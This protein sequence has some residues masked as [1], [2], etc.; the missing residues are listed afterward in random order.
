M[1]QFE[2]QVD[3]RSRSAMTDFLAHHF[4]YWTAN[5]WNRSTSYAH[6]MKID[7][8]GLLRDEVDILYDIIDVPEA[9]KKINVL[10]DDFNRK[11]DYEWQAGFN[12]RSGGYLVLYQGYKK[13]S[14][15]KS[16]CTNCG[17]R[18]YQSVKDTG[19]D[20]CGVCRDHSRVDYE[21]P[22][23]IYGTYPYIG[24]DNGYTAPEDYEDFSLKE[25]QERV[26]IVQDFDQLA[27]NIAETAK[28]L[29]DNYHVEEETI[30]VPK[31][32][33]KLAG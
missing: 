4:R 2:K 25:L 21:T 33:K 8:L 9:Y 20:I 10:I 24:T 17:Q 22:P 32:V 23:Y 18:N 12:G 3:K 7:E 13:P 15:Y 16:F 11:H 28:Y 5:G 14:E 1:K 27:Q 19:N 6:N 31:Q 29:A 26:R 30:M